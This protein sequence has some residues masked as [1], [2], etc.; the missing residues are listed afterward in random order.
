MDMEFKVHHGEDELPREH[1]RVVITS[2]THTLAQQL[3]VPNGDV[4]I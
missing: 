2:D 4:F 1:F 3:N